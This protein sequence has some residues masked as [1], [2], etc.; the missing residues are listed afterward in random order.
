MSTATI[1]THTHV[2]AAQAFIDSLDKEMVFGFAGKAT[3]YGDP[4][5]PGPITNSFST[6]EKTKNEILYI[7][8]VTS[9][10]GHLSIRRVE[11]E[12]DKV[13]TQWSPTENV[14]YQD[15]PCYVVVNNSVYLCV[16]NNAGQPST[17]KPDFSPTYMA[18]ELGDSYMWKWLFN[19]KQS[20]IDEWGSDKY[21]PVP[22]T[23]EELTDEWKAVAKLLQSSPNELGII[24]TTVYDGGR[25][26]CTDAS[27]ANH[28]SL[29]VD[30]D[31]KGA[32]LF[33]GFEL[34]ETKDIESVVQKKVPIYDPVDGSI[35]GYETKDVKVTKTE[36]YFRIKPDTVVIASRGSDYTRA[37]V[38]VTVKNCV[39]V[40]EPRIDLIID[41]STR[42]GLCPAEDIAAR[43]VTVKLE[44]TDTEGDRVIQMKEG[45]VTLG[46]FPVSATYRQVGLI[47]NVMYR[48]G[49]PVVQAESYYDVV[50][51]SN[52]TTKFE[53]NNP[54]EGVTSNA[55]GWILYTE[56]IQG[57]DQRLYVV[58][59][60]GD[61][62]IASDLTVDRNETVESYV[63]LENGEM[64]VTASGVIAELNASAV[65]NM[66][67]SVLYAENCSPIPRSSSQTEV[68]LLTIEL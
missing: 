40:S 45:P 53:S 60:K 58:N 32:T 8:P 46:M 21:I 59:R 36:Y 29:S 57:T 23:E 52:V 25:F 2:H 17:V 9:K 35:T 12:P 16:S 11:W 4:D 49:S 20:L 61:F 62:H 56:A 27:F 30:G 37:S 66:S 65:D 43:F 63:M 19:V 18:T 47:K 5:T 10:D 48:D 14:F 68:F 28:V 38:K 41:C 50:Q 39:I 44:Y 15:T 31:G 67:G 51:L 22:V 34:I 33:Y 6:M 3:S 24:D 7:K 55:S 26:M 42:L 64:E 54:I 1:T 13:Y